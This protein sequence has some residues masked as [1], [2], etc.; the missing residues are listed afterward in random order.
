MI[1]VRRTGKRIASTILDG[2]LGTHYFA[3]LGRGFSGAF[4]VMGT[5]NHAKAC[6]MRP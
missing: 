3:S 1:T 5:H 6:P 4:A 2:T